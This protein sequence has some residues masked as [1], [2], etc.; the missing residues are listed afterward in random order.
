MSYILSLWYYY[1]VILLWSYL[2]VQLDLGALTLNALAWHQ[3]HHIATSQQRAGGA[4]H[5]VTFEYCLDVD[6]IFVDLVLS[7]DRELL[8]ADVLGGA[9]MADYLR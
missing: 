5:G 4:R 7:L 3:Q 1:H 2:L 8:G 9:I 6:L